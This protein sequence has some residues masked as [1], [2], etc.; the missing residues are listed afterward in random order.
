KE[1][2][3]RR[4]QLESELGAIEQ[5]LSRR[6][7]Y[8]QQLAEV[9][10]ELNQTEQETTAQ[11]QLVETLRRAAEALEQQKQ[12]LQRAEE[13]WRRAQDEVQRHS[14]Q[15]AEHQERIAQYQGI[16]ARAEEIRQGH[17]RLQAA[18]A[19]ETELSRLRSALMELRVQEQERLKQIELAQQRLTG[20]ARDK[21]RRVE[22]LVA[23]A[24]AI[25]AW[26]EERETA[27]AELGGLA[28]EE[29]AL[30]AMGQEE[31][32]ALAEA[33]ALYAASQQIESEIREL[34]R[35]AEELATPDLSGRC[36]LCG[37]DLG[38]EE[39]QH[40]RDHYRQEEE[41][42][43]QTLRENE[44]RA[45][46]L[47]RRAEGLSRQVGELEASLRQ[48]RT[49]LDQ[50]LAVLKRQIEEGEAAEKELGPA[51]A[52]LA[53]LEERLVKEDYAR[54]ERRQVEDIRQ[55][56][57]ALAYDPQAH[58]E[59]RRQVKELAEFEERFR[60]LG[61][62]EKLLEREQQ[63]LAT[64]EEN[65]ERW[66]ERCEETRQEAEGLRAAVARTAGGLGPQLG[67]AREKLERLR[68][69]ERRLGQ[70]LG[71]L[72]Q[73]LDRCRALEEER[74]PK[75]EALNQAAATK[76]AYDELAVAFGKNGV[77][78]LIIDGV[79][80]EITDEANRL[81]NQ[82][83]SGRMSVTMSTQR[84]S[85]KGT[86][87]ETLDI[88]IADEL[89]TRSYE[90]FSGGEAFRINFALRIA[91]SRLLARRAG[92]PLPTLVIDEGFGTQDS[93]GRQAL[94]EAIQA[95]Q[96]DFR[97]LLV[98]THIDELREAFPVRIE[99]TKTPEGSAIAV[100]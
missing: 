54:E 23:W 91:L 22:E 8:E 69:E 1:A 100:T 7:E 4:R 42:R 55:E 45:G 70:A 11:E 84:E 90:M 6:G 15:M 21:A 17:Q 80:P 87:V 62:A 98:I 36:P 26:R 73:E 61:Q 16:V 31:R 72:R 18:R 67:E 92:A 86:V 41:V 50:R 28:A 46:D 32:G 44:D 81:L 3:L 35:K 48:R 10:E 58:E 51:R 47:S 25:P 94:V 49:G 76:A 66:Q 64:A 77:Q 14:R 39:V 65:R 85:Q 57:A 34:R 29:E 93:A 97:C 27:E 63:A 60:Q 20:E 33:Q 9:A 75:R 68:G 53:A 99:V 13:Q 89:G 96:D 52:D 2:D 88:K 30:A 43:E 19:Q 79:L 38:E 40:I 82:M 37:T 56:M 24:A 5:E 59:A 83:T 12:Q 95:I 78:A 71:A 74:Q